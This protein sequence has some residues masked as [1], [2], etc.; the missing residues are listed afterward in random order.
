[1]V[2]GRLSKTQRGTEQAVKVAKG[3]IC[4]A[5]TMLQ[6]NCSVA[7]EC[8]TKILTCIN[9]YIYLLVACEECR[10]ISPL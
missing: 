3:D 8:T 2:A 7:F 1:M 4:I 5:Q 10:T 6:V 9:I